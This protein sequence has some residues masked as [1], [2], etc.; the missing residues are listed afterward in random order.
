MTS[1]STSNRIE[2]DVFKRT[3]LFV[4]ETFERRKSILRRV[5]SPWYLFSV[6]IMYQLRI[7]LQRTTSNVLARSALPLRVWHLALITVKLE[8][9]EQEKAMEKLDE[10]QWTSSEARGGRSL[11]QNGR[12]NTLHYTNS[13]C[14]R[15]I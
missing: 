15:D 8:V 3:P 9:R 11:S 6:M 7:L 12:V 14:Y 2:I 1:T 4:R 10:G 13:Q 5:C